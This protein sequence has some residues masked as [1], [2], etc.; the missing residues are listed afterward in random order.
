MKI[1]TS[2]NKLI[3]FELKRGTS[4][5]SILI[6]LIFTGI[7]VHIGEMILEYLLTFLKPILPLVWDKLLTIMMYSFE[8]NLIGIIIF[9]V[10]L[11]PI[12]RKLD[13]FFLKRV[14]EEIIFK[15]N[16]DS[17]NKGWNLNY[18]GSNNPNKTNRIENSA[19]I[20]EANENELKDSK[21]EYGAYLD[22]KSGIYRGNQY[23]VS[24]KVRGES[25]TTMQFL[26]WLHDTRSENTS[27][28]TEYIVPTKKIQIVKLKFTSNV[29]EAMRIHLHNK[30]G[31]GKIFIDEVIIKKI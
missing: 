29:T 23:E 25:N 19:M 17:G 6:A 7:F 21:K 30:S 18:W 13:K 11:F 15:D 8:I 5:V 28:K 4:F 26:L 14:K 16:F 3:P 20:F 2:I 31:L 22:F 27:I 9:A 10:L 12:Y 24:C 1:I